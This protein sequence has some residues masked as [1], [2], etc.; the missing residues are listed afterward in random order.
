M[1]QEELER[2]RNAAVAASDV[3]EMT[4]ETRDEPLV[5]DASGDAL[6]TRSQVPK[7]GQLVR[8]TVLQN[9]RQVSVEEREE[10]ASDDGAAARQLQQ[11]LK[12]SRVSQIPSPFGIVEEP[13]A[14]HDNKADGRQAAGGSRDDKANASP[15][16]HSVEITDVTDE[17]AQSGEDQQ[18]ATLPE[19]SDQVDKAQPEPVDEVVEI[20]EILDDVLPVSSGDITPPDDNKLAASVVEVTEEFEQTVVRETLVR[21]PSILRETLHE[22]VEDEAEA[23]ATD[24]EPPIT[25]L[26]A[27]SATTEAEGGEIDWNIL[28]E[29]DRHFE[30]CFA[31]ELANDQPVVS[32]EDDDKSSFSSSSTSGSSTST[33]T[34]HLGSTTNSMEEVEVSAQPTP[35]SIQPEEMLPVVEAETSA[36]LAEKL[37]HDVLEDA[38]KESVSIPSQ[39]EIVSEPEEQPVAELQEMQSSIPQSIQLEKSPETD[40]VVVLPD[41]KN[42][43]L[44]ESLSSQSPTETVKP[45]EIKVEAITQPDQLVEQEIVQFIPEVTKSRNLIVDRE[46]IKQQSSESSE[47]S[48][49]EEE[50]VIQLAEKVVDIL[51]DIVDQLVKVEQSLVESVVNQEEPKKMDREEDAMEHRGS[52]APTLGEN[53]PGPPPPDGDAERAL[54]EQV[55][56]LAVST[57][58]PAMEAAVEEGEEQT[59]QQAELNIQWQEIQSLL[60]DRLDQLRQDASSSTHSST[61]RYLATV[62]Q[63]TVE[64]SVEERIVKLQDNLAALR[65]AVQSREVVVIQR[66]VITIVRTVTEW[67]ETIEYRVYTIKQTKSMERRTEQIQSL[68]EQVRVVEESL[69]T[70]NNCLNNFN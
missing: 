27:A 32:D 47:S 45:E 66:I 40:L 1:E 44:D 14:T 18:A 12:R 41:D 26:P 16:R 69:H 57:A 49:D 48:S 30:E 46:D 2:N 39:T 38:L 43:P 42:E 19:S 10:P 17:Y 5:G 15:G 60:A 25:E 65:T 62:T 51:P 59:A 6:V 28:P 24:K 64:E 7:T 11:P 9:G 21:Q 23:E 50:Q 56:R 36:N 54:L 61:V 3:G 20:Q 37:S 29:V 8:R 4:V 33:D 58:H 63:V 52:V 67:L 55:V 31:G 53:S 13:I 22:E 35:T 70:V 34:T 68:S